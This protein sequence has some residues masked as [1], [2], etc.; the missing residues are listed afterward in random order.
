MTR[1]IRRNFNGKPYFGSKAIKML[2]ITSIEVQRLLFADIY[3][4]YY[5]RNKSASVRIMNM[6][7]IQTQLIAFWKREYYVT[8]PHR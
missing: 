4:I 6:D 8:G 3:V 5:V 2:I 7:F 1:I